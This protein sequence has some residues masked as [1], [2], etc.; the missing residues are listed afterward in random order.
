MNGFNRI[1]HFPGSGGYLPGY[2]LHLPGAF[3]DPF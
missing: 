3:F 2:I 1:A